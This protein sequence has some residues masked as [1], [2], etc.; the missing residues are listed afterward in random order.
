LRV[1]V[2][3]HQQVALDR[4][5]AHGQ[6]WIPGWRPFDELQEWIR[7][8]RQKAETAGRDP[9]SS[10]IVAPQFSCL[11]APTHEEA[12]RRYMASG[13]VQHRKSLAYTGRDPGLAMD[14]NLIG[15]PEAVLEKLARLE[16][17]GVD[18]LACINVL[19]GIPGGVRGAGSL[20]RPRGDGPVPWCY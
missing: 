17:A 13:M 7:L 19:C 6:G 3:G 2:G 12:T 14:N 4:A 9:S 8:L 20:L 15:S 18:H 16:R 1:L 11:V 10:L 5:V